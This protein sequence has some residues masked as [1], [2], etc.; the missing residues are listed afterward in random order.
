MILF[1]FNKVQWSNDKYCILIKYTLYITPK[2]H[3]KYKIPIFS[4]PP[5]PLTPK[6]HVK[7]KIP[8]FSTPPLL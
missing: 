7:Y 6:P 1:F 3:V 5:S 4:T 8:I 2:P